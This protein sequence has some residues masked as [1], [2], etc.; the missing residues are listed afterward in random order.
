M[1]PFFKAGFPNHF[2]YFQELTYKIVNYTPDLKK[3]EVEETIKK[4]LDTWSAVSQ[5]KFERVTD[6]NKEADIMIKFVSGFHGDSRPADG[7][8]KELA[9]AFFP[10][11]NTGMVPK[12]L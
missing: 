1:A 10:L 4:S 5:L 11:D 6:P 2:L 3:K 8:G 7:P 9:H 12:F